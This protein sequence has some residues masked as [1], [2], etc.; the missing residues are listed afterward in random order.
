M[1]KGDRVQHIDKE[2]EGRIK[3]INP[4]SISILSTEGFV[5]EFPP[6]KLVRI[7]N[8]IDDK[9]NRQRIPLKDSATP[10]TKRSIKKIP[11]L[12]LHIEKLL[13]SHQHLD[14]TSKLDLQ[15]KELEAFLNKLKRSHHKEAIVIHGHG[16]NILKNKIMQFLNHKGY[17]YYEASYA[18]YGGGALRIR[19]KK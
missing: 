6:E 16:K 7:G 15:I 14:G 12:D 10:K 5:Y 17:T 9:L 13:A 11:E 19:L 4:G 8:A 3:A 2:I 1:K 18:D